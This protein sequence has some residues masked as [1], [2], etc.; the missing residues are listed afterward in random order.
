MSID[1]QVECANKP[2]C[3]NARPMT[4]TNS[5]S[6]SAPA[7]AADVA[8]FADLGLPPELLS[9]LEV[10]GYEAPTPIQART[11]PPLLAGRDLLGQAQTGTGKTAAFALPLL[12]RLDLKLREPQVL[13]LAPTRELAL[14]VAEAFQRYAA[15]LPGFHVLPVYGGQ[16]YATQ[17]RAL[18]RGVHVVVGTP[19]RVMDH[20]RQG[21]LRLEGLSAI[22]LDEADEMLRMG[23]LEDV[24]WILEQVPQK[25]QMALF[26]ATLPA[27]VRQI[28][29][30]HMD[31][32]E[33][34]ALESRPTA[35]STVRQRAWIV[36]GTHKLDALTRILETEEHDGVLVF[37]RTRIATSELAEKL[38]ARGIAAAPLSGEIPQPARER[39]VAKLKK[40]ELDVLVATDVAARGLDL[41]R[42]SH[43]VNYDIP[44]DVDS[45]V[46]R[47]GRT[48]R[49]GRSGEAI[50]FVA[51][52]ER[53]MLRTIERATGSVIHGMDLPTTA[54]VNEQRVARF[55]LR[56]TETATGE[57]LSFYKKLVSEL[58]EEG[59]LTA[60]DA[61]AALAR[62]AQGEQP[63]LLPDRPKSAREEWGD[64]PQRERDD[65]PQRSSHG[66]ERGSDRGPYRGPDRGPERG[67][68]DKDRAPRR[69]F[70]KRAP[71]PLE[72]G[73]VRY[74]IGV[75][76]VH[77]VKPGNIV[78]CIANEAGIEGRYIGHI[79]IY[80]EDS[81]VDLPEG[82]PAE[83]LSD[84]K[85]AKIGRQPLDI[86]PDTGGDRG[87]DRG[88]YRGRS[89][90]RGGS[91]GGYRKPFGKSKK[92]Y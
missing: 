52:R 89:D 16:G 50:L 88:G 87:G 76:H 91:T 41:D 42:I 23:F 72:D 82:M 63:L 61:G 11:I 51:H 6:P 4:T 57:D 92:Q 69:D 40:G 34:A 15:H 73:M 13:V 35:A 17:L 66:A 81:T 25:K 90:D 48:G 21:K 28:A 79:A 68:F 30:K 19:G 3:G 60:I 26:S 54:E 49:A 86:A 46:H 47:I 39:T 45:Y 83:I 24:L 37:V 77:G 74:R 10:V 7:L 18:Q 38:E 8:T 36:N 32:P 55:K 5:S 27:E 20:M 84:L 59:D 44:Y 1:G 75:G 65:R 78:G 64:K 29:K 14:Q 58:V 9:A 80:D 31:N 43:V 12:A 62:M 71:R 56:I 85:R 22:V 53:R 2:S 70:P 67:G 33:V